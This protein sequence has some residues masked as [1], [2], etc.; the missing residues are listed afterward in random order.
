MQLTLKDTF[1]SWFTAMG[2]SSC[3][4]VM[5]LVNVLP[6]ASVHIKRGGRGEGGGGLIYKYI[7]GVQG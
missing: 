1:R 2:S 4:R 5:G 3:G 7:T 6:G